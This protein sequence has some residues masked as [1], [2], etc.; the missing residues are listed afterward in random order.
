MEITYDCDYQWGK[1][2]EDVILEMLDFAKHWTPNESRERYDFHIW[3]GLYGF[4]RVGVCLKNLALS[5][6]YKKQFKTFKQFCE[7]YLNISAGLAKQYIKAAET[8]L[9]LATTT[10]D[11]DNGD[12]VKRFSVLPQNI[13]QTLPLV[14]LNHSE[15]TNGNC[16]LIDKWEQVLDYSEKARGGKITSTTVKEI[17]DNAPVQKQIAVDEDLWQLIGEEAAKAGLSKKDFLKKAVQ[18]YLE[19]EQ[20]EPVDEEAVNRWKDDLADLLEENN[21]KSEEREAETEDADVERKYHYPDPPEQTSSKEIISFGQLTP[22]VTQGE[23]T[24]TCRNWSQSTIDRYKKLYSS[25]KW[26]KAYDKLPF[27]GGKQFGWIALKKPPYQKRLN[28]LTSWDFEKEG[29][30]GV[31]ATEFRDRF[32]PRAKLSDK[33]WVIEFEFRP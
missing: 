2:K 15:D 25:A 22:L 24:M 8:W 9:Q 31:T 29:L 13:S 21:Y 12:T 10:A 3:D 18:K 7:K 26:I 20:V 28:D 14:K 11:N 6:A 16:E 19:P 23:K 30:P 17:V 5:K 1:A 32:F 4:V 33:V 27:A